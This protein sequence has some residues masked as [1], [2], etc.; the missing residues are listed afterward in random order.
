MRKRLLIVAIG[1]LS[2]GLFAQEKEIEQAFNAIEANDTGTAKSAIGM[3]VGKVDS[4]T[5]DPET[6][7]KYYYTAGKI[8]LS[9]G[10][11]MDAA[12]MFKSLGKIENGVIYS[13][14]N[15]NSKTIEF[16][17]DKADADA[18]E[19]TGNYSKAKEIKL[20]PNLIS[21]VETDLRAKAENLLK[22]GND[23]FRANNWNSAGDKFLE[24]SYMVEA[25]GGDADLFKFNAGMSYHKGNEYQKAFDVYKELIQHGY[26]GE[27]TTWV[28][29]NKETGEDQVFSSKEDADLQ[30]KLGIV[31]GVKM[32]KTESIEKDLFSYAL[33]A[34]ASMK[35]YDDIVNV[36]E[37]KYPNDPDIQNLIGNVYHFSGNEDKF[38]SQLMEAAKLD[39][40]NPTNFYNIG[41]L[42]GDKGDVAKAKEYYEK[43]IQIDPN[44]KNAYN[45]IALLI[46]KPEDEYVEI[47]NK[48]LGSSAKEKALYKEY[49]A[50]RKALYLEAIPYL[51]KAFNADKKDY[52]SAKAL[53]QA[54]SV[55]E[56]YDKEDAMRAIENS[57]KP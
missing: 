36:I 21:K 55:A 24:A 28:G 23:A 22:Q 48:N 16:Y 6:M 20:T 33:N 18:A 35:K 52:F 1:L 39:P 26:T 4:K 30:Q 8:A 14:K 29:K 46:I 47:I 32:S 42:Y 40:K 2:T 34:L 13:I 5:I 57:L 10:R 9:E 27:K 19:A 49:S 43:A 17:S 31:T 3:I 56:L 44:Y 38:L 45:N 7:A 53:R 37:K 15:K 11:T 41:V 51:E 12:K 25:L 54:Y 50:K